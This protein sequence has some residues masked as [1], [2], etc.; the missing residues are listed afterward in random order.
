MFMSDD[1]D[2]RKWVERILSQHRDPS[3][4]SLGGVQDFREF[5]HSRHGKLGFWPLEIV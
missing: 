5:P 2:H 1:W 3:F 4:G